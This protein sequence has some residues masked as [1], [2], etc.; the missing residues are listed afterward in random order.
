MH[1]VSFGCW[2]PKLRVIVYDNFNQDVYKKMVVFY[3]K[4]QSDGKKSTER[5]RDKYGI[6]KA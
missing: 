1:S 3:K 5:K 6:G 4:I 2:T